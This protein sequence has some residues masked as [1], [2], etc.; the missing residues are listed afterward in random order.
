MGKKLDIKSGDRF[1]RLTII[2][3]VD[4]RKKARFFLCRC[5]CG[6]EK[7]IRMVLL[8][9]GDTK[10]CGCY[11]REH[12]LNMIYKNGLSRTKPYAI[13][14]SMKQRCC[15]KNSKAYEH[16][17]ARGVR[18]CDEWMDFEI[19]YDWTINNGYQE[20]L[21]LERIDVNGNYEPSNCTWIPQSEQSNNTR[22][23][24]IILYEGKEQNL[25]QWANELNI[26]Y[27]TLFGRLSKGWSIK[28]AFETPVDIKNRNGRA[29]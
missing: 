25:R 6:I 26:K 20:G 13:W 5:D 27:D 29:K 18:V 24:R 11:K 16:Y 15:N 3:E 19:F 2:K 8:T 23:S 4:S 21:T 10:S 14:N 12:L 22:R 17:G 9:N 1:S 28:K 7:E